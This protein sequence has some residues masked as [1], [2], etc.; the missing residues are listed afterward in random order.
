MQAQC[1]NT[2]FC[3]FVLFEQ[4]ELVRQIPNSCKNNQMRDVFFEEIECDDPERYVRDLFAGQ[5]CRYEIDRR[6]DGC[7]TV[8]VETGQ[9]TQ[10]F[11]F[12]PLED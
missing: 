7:V 12:T 1:R 3:I 5:D 10:Q 11:Y 8:Y 6:A 4:Y 2:A 9:L